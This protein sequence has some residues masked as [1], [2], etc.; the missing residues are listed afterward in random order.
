[1]KCG[2]YYT[3]NM[4]DTK[5]MGICQDQLKS[6]KG[7]IVSVSTKPIDFGRN[8]CL[9]ELKRSIPGMVKRILTALENSVGDVVFFLED[10]VLYHPSHFDF[11]PPRDDIYYY[12]VNNW[13]W[14]YPNDR[15]ITYNY[16]KSLSMMCCYRKLALSHYQARMDRIIKNKWDW[17]YEKEADWARAWG[18][19]P[20]TKSIHNGGFSNEGHDI[21]KS[22]FPNI[23]IRHPKA[24]TRN[25][26]TLDQFK[27]L[28]DMRTWKEIKLDD[29]PGWNIKNL[30][31]LV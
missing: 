9:P 15:A 1:M 17:E 22:E 6:F 27:H 14:D 13:R 31:S 11:T 23:D 2:I 4:V 29:L 24:L 7:E 21:W 26:T 5:I 30:W 8:I 25:K 3:V 18:H 28:P 12:N 19:E 10:D 16:M 20:G